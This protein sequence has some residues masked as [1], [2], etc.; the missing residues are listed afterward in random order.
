MQVQEAGAWKR[1]AEFMQSPP[2]LQH[3][4]SVK[5]Q[6]RCH[7]Q[8]AADEHVDPSRLYKLMD[9]DT[10]SSCNLSRLECSS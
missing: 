6:N 5:M 10:L 2:E 4:R 9:V 3:G 1:H 8:G 7:E